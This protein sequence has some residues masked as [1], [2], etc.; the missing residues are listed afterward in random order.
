MSDVLEVNHLGE[1]LAVGHKDERVKKITPNNLK[2]V[3]PLSIQGTQVKDKF[4]GV[5]SKVTRERRYEWEDE[6]PFVC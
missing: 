4:A 2:V 6:F 3:L 1:L 5:G